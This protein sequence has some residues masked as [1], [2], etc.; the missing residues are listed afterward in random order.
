MKKILAIVAGD[1]VVVALLWWRWSNFPDHGITTTVVCFL[2]LI[3]ILPMSVMV[4]RFQLR[5]RSF[6]KR[7]LTAL[8]VV[9]DIEDTG[10]IERGQRQVRM[11]V[12]Y[13]RIDG[14]SAQTDTIVMVPRRMTPPPGGNATVW[15]SPA[16]DE[17]LVQVRRA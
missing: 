12:Q 6:K 17:T 4:L 8:G 14:S 16:D 7:A 3:V 1:F 10:K 2:P 13:T 9:T 15:Y 5:E 11:T